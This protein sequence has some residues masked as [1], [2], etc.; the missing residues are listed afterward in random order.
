MSAFDPTNKSVEL[1]LGETKLTLFF[2]FNAFAAFQQRTG[3]FFLDWYF[4]VLRRT[5][6]LMNSAVE[7]RSDMKP[8]QVLK[9]FSEREVSP[10]ELLG[11]S[12]I[13]EMISLIWACAYRIQRGEVVRDYSPAEIGEMLDI[14]NYAETIRVVLDAASR[15]LPKKKAGPEAVEDEPRPTKP[16]RQNKRMSG[17]VVS[18]P[19][20][21]EILASAIRR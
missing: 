10:F 6:R 13:E 16:T 12:P 19:S 21:D 2:T 9:A 20:D 14:E 15:N 1:A 8:E 18:G 17:G 5:Q 3:K 7:L 11:I 4:Q